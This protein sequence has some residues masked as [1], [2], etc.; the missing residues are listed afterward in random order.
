[1]KGCNK[2]N[3]K[4]PFC[5]HEDVLKLKEKDL[6]ILAILTC[7]ADKINYRLINSLEG[8]DRQTGLVSDNNDYSL[9]YIK[10]TELNIPALAIKYNT[11]PT[12]IR[13][14]LKALKDINIGDEIPLIYVN[15]SE[16]GTVYEL[17]HKTFGNKYVIVNKKVIEKLLAFKKATA[18][19]LY[20]V[21][22]YNYDYCKSQNRDCVL[23]IDYLC[24]SVGLSSQSRNYISDLLW[25]LD[26][27]VIKIGKS[28]SVEIVEKNGCV[29]NEIRTHYK[30]EIIEDVDIDKIK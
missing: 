10:R 13:R 23:T 16:N 21:I 18:L 2:V 20:L 9:K 3:K 22:K 11:S 27:K 14:G 25:W 29:H 19:K 15:E 8:F 28:T 5:T 1:M 4:I 7:E 26:D 6:N 30:Y 24:R 12:T 17:N